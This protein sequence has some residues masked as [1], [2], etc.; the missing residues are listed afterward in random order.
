MIKII[1]IHYHSKL[2]ING[3]SYWFSVLTD[4]RDRNNKLAVK[5]P[6]ESNTVAMLRK[7]G[8]DWEEIYDHEHQ[9]PIRQ[10][11]N[12]KDFYIK[13]DLYHSWDIIKAVKNLLK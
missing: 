12:L 6:H 4:T 8:L 9:L 11:N 3:N 2:D 5:T 13:N 7:A 10:F 1:A